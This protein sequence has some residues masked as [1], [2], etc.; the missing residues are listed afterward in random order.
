MIDHALSTLSSIFANAMI[1]AMLFWIFFWDAER[2]NPVRRYLVPKISRPFI[3]L[4]LN[5]EWTMFTPDPPKRDVWPMA[6]MTQVDGSTR[7]WEP[8]RYEALSILEKLRHKKTLKLYFRVTGAQAD[9]H[10]KRDFVEYLLRRDP[11]GQ[12]CAKIDL[13]SVALD[14][15]PYGRRDGTPPQPTKKLI[16]TFHPIPPTSIAVPQPMPSEVA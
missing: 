4:G 9:N 8:R 2:T 11:E 16:F 12:G 7:Y 6:V 13:Y 5:A 10:L 1:V 15:P 14:A 3:W